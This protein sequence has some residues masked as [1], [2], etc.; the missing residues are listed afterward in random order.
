MSEKKRRC[1]IKVVKWDSFVAKILAEGSEK[2]IDRNICIKSDIGLFDFLNH[3]RLRGLL[4]VALTQTKPKS[5]LFSCRVLPPFVWVPQKGRRRLLLLGRRKERMGCPKRS[6]GLAWPDLL[7]EFPP[8]FPPKAHFSRFLVPTPAIKY[9]GA[10]KASSLFKSPFLPVPFLYE[11][12]S[13]PP[14]CT[15]SKI[16]GRFHISIF[17]KN[18]FLLI[19]GVFCSLSLCAAMT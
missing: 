10:K 2:T 13:L 14:L 8:S 15:S 18:P 19:I 4:K 3:W 9:A 17:E 1:I 5:P 6:R 7:P 12:G 11:R 16:R